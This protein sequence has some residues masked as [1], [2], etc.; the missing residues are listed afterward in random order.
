[1]ILHIPALGPRGSLKALGTAMMACR[2]INPSP[3]LG[4]IGWGIF[5]RRNVVYISLQLRHTATLVDGSGG[6]E[7]RGIL[8]ARPAVR[9]ICA[10]VT[11]SKECCGAWCIAKYRCS[12][13]EEFKVVTIS[14]CET[15]QS[16]SAAHSHPKGGLEVEDDAEGGTVS[17][18]TEGGA[19][20]GETVTSDDSV[21][22]LITTGKADTMGSGAERAL[23]K[24]KAKQSGHLP[25]RWRVNIAASPTTFSVVKPVFYMRW[26]PGAIFWPGVLICNAVL[27]NCPT[28]RLHTRHT[29]SVL[30][31]P[32]LDTPRANHF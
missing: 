20:A 31:S 14:S 25:K 23:G 6:V 18:A 21:P 22:S 9:I 2:S 17:G 13:V 5:S 24:R 28:S 19:D 7:P 12:T 32:K 8:S 11:T 29:S 27:K 1:M 26:M 3:A 16:E 10:S 15:A 4:G 30:P